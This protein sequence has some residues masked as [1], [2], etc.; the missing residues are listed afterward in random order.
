MLDVDGKPSVWACLICDWCWPMPIGLSTLPVHPDTN[1][2]PRLMYDHH[3]DIGTPPS[4]ACHL[5]D[6]NDT[7][8]PPRPSEKRTNGAP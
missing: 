2:C 3:A 7:I 6:L 4:K 5:L 8:C 1:V